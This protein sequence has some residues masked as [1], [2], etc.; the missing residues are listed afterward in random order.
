MPNKIGT[1]LFFL[2]VF[3]YLYWNKDRVDINTSYTELIRFKKNQIR[4]IS[5]AINYIDRPV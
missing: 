5:F 1:I 3:F 4:V 2:F